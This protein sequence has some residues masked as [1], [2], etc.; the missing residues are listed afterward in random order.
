M[1]IR[2]LSYGQS[3]NWPAANRI[4]ITLVAASVSAAAN[5][6]GRAP[7]SRPP[8]SGA[9]HSRARDSSGP[10]FSWRIDSIARHYASFAHN[11]PRVGEGRTQAMPSLYPLYDA[12]AH[13]PEGP[14]APLQPA[15]PGLIGSGGSRA[16]GNHRIRTGS[17]TACVRG[18]TPDNRQ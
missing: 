17:R 14:H 15:R 10:A 3:V 12:M 2:A 8:F 16:R 18:D 11:A 9:L 13:W 1:R 5:G 6:D 4:G 7:D